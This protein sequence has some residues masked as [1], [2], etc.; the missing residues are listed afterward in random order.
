M[1]IHRATKKT[2]TVF[3]SDIAN[4]NDKLNK[5]L[6]G[7]SEYYTTGKLSNYIIE[8]KEVNNVIK[9]VNDN[10]LLPKENVKKR[11]SKSPNSRSPSNKD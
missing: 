1:K 5:T 4:Y 3:K 6:S 2:E 10:I 9:N 11:R 8:D 7:F